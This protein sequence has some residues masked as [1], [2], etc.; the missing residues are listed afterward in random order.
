MME[1]NIAFFGTKAGL[2]LL[3]AIGVG[4]AGALLDKM[5]KRYVTDARMKSIREFIAYWIARPGDWIGDLFTKTGTK[6]PFIG[7]MWNKTFEPWV[8][9][10]LETIA[11]GLV[12]GFRDLFRRII[13]AMQSDNPSTKG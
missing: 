7:K 9:I 12:D 10:F 11:L 6:L 4:S 13:K 8:I 5:F 1:S 3:G 2:W